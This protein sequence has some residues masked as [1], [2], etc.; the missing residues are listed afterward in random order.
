M[1][2]N[3]GESSRRNFLRTVG[4]LAVTAIMAL[5]PSVRAAGSVKTIH[6]SPSGND[7]A[8]GSR[9]H[10]F[11]TFERAEKEVAALKSSS[12]AE[13]I[14][15]VEVLFNGGIYP[16]DKPI[17]IGPEQG[18]TVAYPVIY[19]ACGSTPPVFTG[20]RTITGWA[21][22]TNGVW[23]V[24]L[25]EVKAGSWNIAQLFVNGTRRFRPRLP[26][27]NYF[28]TTNDFE[29]SEKGI[30]GFY[31]EEDGL[32]PNWANLSDIEFHTLHIWSASRVRPQS[33]DARK[34]IVHFLKTR[35]YNQYW[36]SFKGPGWGEHGCRFWAENVKEA[37]GTPGEWY[38]DRPT[39]TLSYMPMPGENPETAHVEVPVLSQLLIVEGRENESVLNTLVEGLVFRQ[40]QW[41]TPEEG[42][43]TPQGEINIPAA[44]EFVNARNITVR[45]CVFTQLAG[46]AMAFGPGTHSNMVESCVMTD[47]GA[48][49]VKIGPPYAGYSMFESIKNDYKST[50]ELADID[51]TSAITVWNCRIIGGGRIH[52][53]AHGIWIGHSS[54]N[55][56]LNN[57][58]GDL[59]YTSVSVGWTWGYEVPSRAHDNEIA[60]NHMH[61]IGQGILSDMG[62][63]Y[64]L[65]IS[66]GTTV[67]DNRIHDISVF[68][69]GGGGL[70]PD[71]GS[72]YIHMYNNLVYNTQTGFGQNFGRENIIENNIFANVLKDQVGRSHDEDH[73]SFFFRN[74]II[75][76]NNDASLFSGNWESGTRGMKDGKPIQHYE[77]GRNLYWQASGKQELF[78]GK[79]SLALWQVENGQDADSLVA[80]PFFEN[81]TKNNFRLMPG[82]PAAKIGFKPFDTYTAGPCDPNRL[83]K[84][85]VKPVPTMYEINALKNIPPSDGSSINNKKIIK[86]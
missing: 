20:G 66:P 39:G 10:P 54:Y 57:E 55:R 82:S 75:Y 76:W 51:K 77:L 81:P 85:A 49:G 29:T 21:V 68:T 2:I 41:I 5:W 8:S 1:G 70:Y 74:N 23:T 11:A 16:L 73:I 7:A 56:I 48:G 14:E 44:A 46:Y 31:Y 33:I 86:K 4:M 67:H 40:T 47:L 22:G 30:N 42:N 61:H 45:Q 62:G 15:R 71:Q 13:P 35:K 38:L 27:H 6:V 63:V 65:G 84:F 18:G 64:T 36:G 50:N 12:A 52:P 37:F 25:P 59:Y 17:V 3:K 19:R 79:K 80:D 28:T 60:F 69:Y 53:A 83:P 26:K 24:H 34:K 72:S 58:I 43:F 32:D 78:P 9:R